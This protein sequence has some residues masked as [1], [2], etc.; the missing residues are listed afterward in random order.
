[1]QALTGAFL[2]GRDLQCDLH[3][4]GRVLEPACR[5][6]EKFAPLF[7]QFRLHEDAEASKLDA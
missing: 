5:W 2:Q 7:T 3:G 6:V 1:M 4:Q